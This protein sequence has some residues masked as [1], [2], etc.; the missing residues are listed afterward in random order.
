M[1]NK[2]EGKGW[3]RNIWGTRVREKDREEIYGEQGRKETIVMEKYEM[4][5]IHT[6]EELTKVFEE[7]E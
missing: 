4:K 5:E 3:R 7:E 2:S 6:K 1:G